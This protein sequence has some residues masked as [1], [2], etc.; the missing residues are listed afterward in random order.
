MVVQ[1]GTVV[2]RRDGEM[3]RAP[4]PG[5]HGNSPDQGKDLVA[6]RVRSAAPW[7]PAEAGGPAHHL[8]LPSDAAVLQFVLSPAPKTGVDWAALIRAVRPLAGLALLG[9]AA[10][11]ATLCAAKAAKS[12]PALTAAAVGLEL[13][14]AYVAVRAADGTP[15]SDPARQAPG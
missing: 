7:H 4:L 8:E 14:L 11:A 6:S 5:G 1:T 12:P 9:I 13:A 15:L 3:T 10:P 2:T